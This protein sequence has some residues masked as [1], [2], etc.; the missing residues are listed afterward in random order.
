MKKKLKILA[1]VA[2]IATL[3]SFNAIPAWAQT[4]WNVPGDNSGT[5]TMGNPSCDTIQDAIDAATSGDTVNVADGTFAERLNINK[6]LTLVG[7]NQGV[8]PNVAA[9]GAES[10]ITEAGLGTP[11]PDVL[12]EIP[13]GNTVTMTGSRL[14]A[15]RLPRLLT[16]QSC[17]PSLTTL[18]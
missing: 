6:S 5:C 7:A 14:M 9:R 10:I 18:P 8:D 2:V 16:P 11:N 3:I 17:A 12:I 13:S 15:T 1:V 4:T